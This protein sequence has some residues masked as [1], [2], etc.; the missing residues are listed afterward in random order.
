MAREFIATAC[1]DYLLEMH[2]LTHRYIRV[3]PLSGRSTCVRGLE[4]VDLLIRRG[5][6]VALVGQSGSGKSTLARCLLRLEEPSAGEILFEGRD[7]LKLSPKGLVE[8][9]KKIQLIFRIRHR[10]SI[11]DLLCAKLLR[12]HYTFTGWD[13]RLCGANECGSSWSKWGCRENG[14][15]SWLWN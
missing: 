7:I 5:S 8:V 3:N 2:G 9:R 14:V 13:R 1:S 4:G 11:R 15:K 6:T 10:P 12:N